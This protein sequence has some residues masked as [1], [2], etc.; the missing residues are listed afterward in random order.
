MRFN[1]DDL[2]EKGL[3]HKKT[4]TDGPFAGLSVLKYKNNVFWDNLWHMDERLLECRGMVVD[5]DD[6]V[7]I[8]PFTKIFNRFENDTDVDQDQV[9]CVPRKVNGFMAALSVYKGEAIV[10]TTGTLDSDFAKMAKDIIVDSTNPGLLDYFLKNAGPC[11]LLFEICDDSD[12]HIVKE[13]SGAYLIGCRAHLSGGMLPEWALDDIAGRYGWKRAG[14]D[15]MYFSDVVK[16]SKKVD[17]EGFVVRDVNN[18]NLLL[19]IKSPHYLAKKF[20]MRGGSN[21]WDMIWENPQEAKKRIDEEYYD[22]LDYI[23]NNFSQLTWS[24]MSSGNRRRLIEGYFHG[25]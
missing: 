23:R 5:S 8:W 18:G 2:V 11:T 20:L 16:A 3:V 9:V 15:N 22:L 17:H 25:D 10:S 21:K 13:E 24:V 1:V 12:P 6:N 14:W 19:K 4:Y 7:V